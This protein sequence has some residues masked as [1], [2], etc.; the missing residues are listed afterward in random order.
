MKSLFKSSFLHYLY[1]YILVLECIL[2]ASLISSMNVRESFLPVFRHK[3]INRIVKT[4]TAAPNPVWGSFPSSNSNQK[5]TFQ[6]PWRE[7]LRES[8]TI[9]LIEKAMKLNHC[10]LAATSTIDN[11]GWKLLVHRSWNVIFVSPYVPD[12]LLFIVFLSQQLI[13]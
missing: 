11:N 7:W 10:L 1:R 3:T 12:Y 13:I 9:H 5:K 8:N 2:H 4:R 6:V